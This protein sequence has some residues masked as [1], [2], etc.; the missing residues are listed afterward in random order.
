MKIILLKKKGAM[1]NITIISLLIICIYLI[2]INIGISILMFIF[3]NI[4]EIINKTKKNNIN[5][6]TNS[7]G[8]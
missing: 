2:K 5:S 6:I 8:N 4:I 3:I 1:F 7:L